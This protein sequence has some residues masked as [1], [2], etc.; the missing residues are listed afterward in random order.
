MI[1]AY[2]LRGHLKC[3]IVRLK[4]LLNPQPSA[5][6]ISY[7]HQLHPSAGPG[8]QRVRVNLRISM[9]IDLEV[10]DSI[11]LIITT[12]IMQSAESVI[13]T[14]KTTYGSI[15]ARVYAKHKMSQI[16][17]RDLYEKERR[18]RLHV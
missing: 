17:W 12:S 5:T 15:T 2:V 16:E 13:Q 11:D 10:L 7:T 14:E 18:G 1:V 9:R 6:P 4:T 8:T 3:L